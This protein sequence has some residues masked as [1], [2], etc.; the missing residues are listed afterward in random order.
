MARSLSPIYGADDNDFA[1]SIAAD[2][3]VPRVGT[4]DI[5]GAVEDMR[6]QAQANTGKESLGPSDLKTPVTSSINK[7]GNLS[8]PALDKFPAHMK[9][10]TDATDTGGRK[11]AVPSNQTDQ[12]G[13]Q[14]SPAYTNETS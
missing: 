3:L 13:K 9:G 4:E 7:G 10:P 6:G 8:Y 2:A 14:Q 5:W 11:S 12:N 1:Q